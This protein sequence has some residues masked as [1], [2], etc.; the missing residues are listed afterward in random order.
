MICPGPVTLL[1]RFDSDESK[2]KPEHDPILDALAKEIADSQ[3]TTTPVET[4]CL[5]GHTDDS[6]KN[7]YNKG[8]GDRRAAAAE[9]ALRK[10]VNGLKPGL[11]AR[12][13]FKPSSQGEESPVADNSTADGKAKNR[14]VEITLGR[15]VKRICPQPPVSADDPTALNLFPVSQKSYGPVALPL[16]A[17]GTFT[18]RGSVFFPADAAGSMDFNRT[19]TSP[20]PIVFM[21]HGNHRAFTDPADPDTD[22]CTDS[23]GFTAVP[24]HE[25][26]DYF[27]RLLARMGIIAVS[28]DCN[29]TCDFGSSATNINQRTA[30]VLASI[31]HFRSLHNGGDPTFAGHI[32][33]DRI[34]LMGHSRGGEAVLL[35]AQIING[36]GSLLR[37]LLGFLGVDLGVKVR[38]VLGLAPSDL[39][40]TNGKP[41][42][43][44]FLTILPA[45]DGD[46]V[47]N[48]GA[49]FYDQAVPSPF[50]CQIYVDNANHNRFNVQWTN[51]DTLTH[52]GILPHAVHQGIL[53]AYG[54]AFFRDVLLGHAMR[55]FLRVD[56][57]PPGV[58]AARI[59]IAF[60]QSGATTV[61]DH[62]DIPIATNTLS[63]PTAQSAGL[64][65]DQHAFSQGG[66]TAFNSSFFGNTTGMVAR[67]TSTS[68]RFRSQLAAPV[69]LT[70]KEIWIR[71][72]EVYNGSTVPP[73][74]TGFKLGLEDVAG[75]I[76]F[77]DSRDAGGLPRPFHRKALDAL[78]GSGSDL[79]KTMPNTLR[80]RASCFAKKGF[81]IT[82]VRAILIQ[83]DRGDKRP[84][85]FDQLQII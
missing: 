2:L 10:K 19:I 77:A 65:A 76:S 15:G 41:D 29:E 14:R 27:Q 63:Q 11:A 1:E 7:F 70:G 32:D 42:G 46:V 47:G 79:T 57:L 80:Y 78:I 30:L 67:S 64:T 56:E 68:G 25:G 18:V 26:F 71:A 50:K 16:G 13:K 40:A 36:L 85:A 6:G 53:S 45:A 43:F 22:H 74:A 62:E 84:L 75:A 23:G 82:Q 55:K 60:E 3:A 8:L 49:K 24:N 48:D 12:L 37:S 61:D 81:D 51:E 21:A 83:M 73:G 17:L 38:G 34:G 9:S 31:L 66:A 72:A 58:P 59:H 54:C 69:D 35:A 52:P 33:L 39:G 44:P 28:V 5:V 20:V 4:V